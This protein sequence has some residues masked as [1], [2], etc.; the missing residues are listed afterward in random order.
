MLMEYTVTL[1]LSQ[2]VYR[3]AAKRA[4]ETNRTIEQV[5][6]AHLLE[7]LQPF[8]SIHVSSNRGAM[9]REAEAYQR[10]HPELVKERMGEYVAIYEGKVVDHDINEDLLLQRRRRNYQG[11]V[12]L[13]RRVESEATS[14]LRLRSP[15][16][17]SVRSAL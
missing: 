17:E 13:I 2:I 7:T 5:L 6:A 3:E 9:L 14:E 11:K 16:F 15:R 1:T 4:H 12:V 8:P 10:L